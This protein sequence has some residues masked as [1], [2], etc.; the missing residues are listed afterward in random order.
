MHRER[1][2]AFALRALMIDI[3]AV[4]SEADWRTTWL[5]HYYHAAFRAVYGPDEP[6]FRCDDC[7][8]VF[9]REEYLGDRTNYGVTKRCIHCQ[10][11]GSPDIINPGVLAEPPTRPRR[12]SIQVSRRFK[13]LERDGF[14][15]RYCGRSAPEVKLEADHVIPKAQGG[16]D[17]MDNLITSCYDCNRGKGSQIL[18]VTI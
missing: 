10:T 2:G 5:W 4:H 6:G 16:D 14:R 9:T 11:Y 15:C 3:T 1:R 17:S 7:Y 18:A 12:R 8:R 13:V